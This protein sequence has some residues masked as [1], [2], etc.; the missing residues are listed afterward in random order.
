MNNCRYCGVDGEYTNCAEAD[1]WPVIFRCYRRQLAQRTQER[2]EARAKL[3]ELTAERDA[4][5]AKMDECRE[6]WMELDDDAFD[7]YAKEWRRV[8]D[9]I[10]T[11]NIHLL[12]KAI[13]NDARVGGEG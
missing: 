2:D 3:A 10:A 12:G 13:L 8:K 11:L 9:A 5:K 6:A 4:L 1:D 7:G